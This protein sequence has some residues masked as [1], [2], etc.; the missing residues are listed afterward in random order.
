[1]MIAIA[2][3][4]AACEYCAAV[5][6]RCR[7][8]LCVLDVS[9]GWT[10]RVMCRWVRVAEDYRVNSLVRPAHVPDMVLLLMHVTRRWR[11]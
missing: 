3:A 4:D 5:F 7:G 10:G 9:M 11:L 2:Q 8:C 6:S 1:M